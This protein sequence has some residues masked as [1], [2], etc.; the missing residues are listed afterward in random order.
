MTER[1]DLIVD[2]SHVPEGNLAHLI[3][4][5]PVSQFRFRNQIFDVRRPKFSRTIGSHR[6]WT[7]AISVGMK[8]PGSQPLNIYRQERA[9][10][11]SE[12]QGKVL[13]HEKAVKSVE[14]ASGR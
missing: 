10:K 9:G 5:E 11:K 4:R 8:I 14:V 13:L 6:A 7:Q 2:F 12:C 3:S 1:A